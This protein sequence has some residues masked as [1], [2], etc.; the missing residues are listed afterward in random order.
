MAR[1][2]HSARIQI[3]Y[4]SI[5]FRLSCTHVATSENM[6]HYKEKTKLLKGHQQVN[7][8]YGFPKEMHSNN[9]RLL[10]FLLMQF[11]VSLLRFQ[12]TVTFITVVHF[13]FVLPVL[14]INKFHT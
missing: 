4:R 8:G 6:P 9:I 13:Y 1:T 11:L 7:L 5:S 2:K 3:K 12:T 10:A 14:A